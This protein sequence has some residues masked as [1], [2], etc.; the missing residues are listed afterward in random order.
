MAD[1]QVHN[2]GRFGHIDELIAE[3]IRVANR[4]DE[5]VETEFNRLVLVAMP[6]MKIADVYRQYRAQLMKLPAFATEKEVNAAEREYEE[7][8][9]RERAERGLG[10]RK[11]FDQ[12]LE[13]VVKQGGWRPGEVELQP[14]D[15]FLL[16][17]GRDILLVRVDDTTPTPGVVLAKVGEEWQGITSRGSWASQVV[18]NPELLKKLVYADND[19]RCHWQYPFVREG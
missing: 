14:G 13:G 4:L 6:A 11:T 18:D 2:N 9:T 3:A 17:R 8:L 5:A 19:R 15:T 1:I 16:R 12:W 10:H 7:K